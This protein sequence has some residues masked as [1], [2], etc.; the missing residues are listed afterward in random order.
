MP[1]KE[2]KDK[3]TRVNHLN[4]RR[5][6]VSWLA[7]RFK[8][9]KDCLTQKKIMQQES[10]QKRNRNRGLSSSHN[11]EWIIHL[12]VDRLKA[13]STMWFQLKISLLRTK[14]H[15]RI[16]L[17]PSLLWETYMRDGLKIHKKQETMW[18]TWRLWNTSNGR[19]SGLIMNLKIWNQKKWLHMLIRCMNKPGRSS[20]MIWRSLK[21]R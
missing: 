4:R 17:R 15:P 3:E 6:L 5:I 13:S 11:K 9:L 16:S 18:N 12:W 14:T 7:A 8:W 21:P 1:R 20:W 10:G 2:K 19:S